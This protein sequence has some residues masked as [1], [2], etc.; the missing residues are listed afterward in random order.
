GQGHHDRPDPLAEVDQDRERGADLA[1]R[2]ERRAGVGPAEERGEHADVSAGGD[3]QEFGQALDQSKD[4]G[5]YEGHGG[6]GSWWRR[7]GGR[8]RGARLLGAPLGGGVSGDPIR[9]PAAAAGKLTA[10]PPPS[11]F[12]RRPRAPL[13]AAAPAGPAERPAAPGQAAPDRAALG[14]RRSDRVTSL[15]MEQRQAGGSGLWVSCTA[16]GTMTWGND[17]DEEAASE[18]LTTFVDA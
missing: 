18:L 7:T 4:D 12:P 1:R 14:R 2:G 16:L 17:T 8:G 15:A 3:R 11:A 6:L 13:T 10:Y 5:L 9:H